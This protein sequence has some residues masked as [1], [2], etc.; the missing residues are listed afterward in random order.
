LSFDTISPIDGRYRTEAKTLAAYS[1]ERALTRE[2]VRVELAYLRLLVK[3]GVAPPVKVPQAV[4]KI[5]EVKQLEKELGHD[6]KAV[7]VSLR[8]SMKGLGA[9]GLGPYVHLGLTSEDTNSLAY[10][11]LLKSALEKVLIP[12]YSSLARDLAKIARK[13]AY[14]AMV[15]RTHGRPALPT[16]F[17]KEI[18]VFAVRIAERVSALRKLRPMAKFSGAVGTYSSFSLLGSRNWPDELAKFVSG[19]GIE[20]ATY[21]TQVVPG[22]RLSDILH[23]IINVNQLVLSLSRDLWLYQTLDLVR[24]V[25]PGKVS[26]ST[27]P[28]KVNPVDLENAEGQVEVSNSLLMLLAYRLQVTRLQRDLSDSVVRRMLGQ[29]LAHSL[30]ASLRLRSSLSSMTVDR[31]AMSRD[32]EKHPEIYA[33]R[34]QVSLRLKGD[35]LGYEKVKAKLDRGKFTR[36]KKEKHSYLGEAPILARTC[37]S[38]VRRL[39]TA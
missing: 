15:A 23:I 31:P 9:A 22:E 30:I 5:E 10:A 36:T 7:E 39:L 25:R 20:P 37:P 18:A 35:E 33:E 19:F 32:L 8:R 38:V 21:S 14:T 1:S 13:E 3:L 26:S 29:A 2:R 4:L 27:M 11:L 6:V 24:F 12:A 16:T 28:Q 17:G 34:E